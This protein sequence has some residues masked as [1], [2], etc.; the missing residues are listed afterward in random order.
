MT[1]CDRI[2]ILAPLAFR[3]VGPKFSVMPKTAMGIVQRRRPRPSEVA[4]AVLTSIVTLGLVGCAGHNQGD[5]LDP[6]KNGLQGTWEYLVTN[7]YTAQFKDCTDA[8]SVLEGATF[9]EGLSLAPI[10]MTGVT[11]NVNQAG[12]EF[13]VPPHQVVCSDGAPASVSGSGLI[14][15]PQVGG[16]W[17]S[18]SSTGVTAI[19]TFSG[20]IAGNTLQLSESSRTFKGSFAGSCEFEPPLTALVTV[21]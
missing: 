16:Q 21:K 19:Q 5:V 2:V 13:D 3:V 9:Y 14:A 18:V 17:E 4:S 1:R 7:A 8:A 20:V 6:S 12:D 11:F 10:C 15:D